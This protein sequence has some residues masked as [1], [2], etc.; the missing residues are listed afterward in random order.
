VHDIA[1]P[2]TPSELG[3]PE[4]GVVIST[5]LPR[6]SGDGD[7]LMITYEYQQNGSLQST[8]YFVRYD[9]TDV[10]NVGR[11][12]FPL[13]A[14]VDRVA[15]SGDPDRVYYSTG[16]LTSGA[17][18]SWHPDSGASTLIRSDDP[19]DPADWVFLLTA[20]DNGD[21]AIVLEN[22]IVFGPSGLNY[23]WEE[24]VYDV[25]GRRPIPGDLIQLFSGQ[26][27]MLGM[28]MEEFSSFLGARR[29]G[30]GN[31]VVVNRHNL[32]PNPNP[33]L[34]FNSAPH[35]SEVFRGTLTHPGFL[36]GSDSATAVDTPDGHTVMHGIEPD[37][38][39]AID[40]QNPG[41]DV[42]V[43][44]PDGT[45][46]RIDVPIEWEHETEHL[47]I[48]GEMLADRFFVYALN[49]IGE[50]D[51][52]RSGRYLYDL[53]SGLHPLPGGTEPP[54]VWDDTY[55]RSPIMVT[56]DVLSV[57]ECVPGP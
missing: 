36:T 52:H 13:P 18:F 20:S 28:E 9:I 17:V 23:Y 24:W 43:R 40:N 15:I 2:P 19:A 12:I 5:S 55:T 49:K 44:D 42:F 6:I 11:E 22:E 8:K 10:A 31:E 25:D 34:P 27:T 14:G 39:P 33:S 50:E 51:F 53:T 3:K 48:G 38:A 41:D 35:I 46:T 16:N 37:D 21:E 32:P 47:V 1:D 45:F 30:S 54:G 26:P 7:T 29:T 57:V 4:D 56:G